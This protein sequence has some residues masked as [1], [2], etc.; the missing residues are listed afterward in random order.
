LVAE[1][2]NNRID[3]NDR[4]ERLGQK[5]KIPMEAMLESQWKPFAQQIDQLEAS[6]SKQSPEELALM[7]DQ[8]ISKNNEIIAAL[9]AIL[10]DMIELQDL[11]EIIDRVRG[12][13]DRESKLIDRSKQQQKKSNLDQLK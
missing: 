11:N 10:A 9:N 7:L 3:S 6:L 1:L 8:S 2:I 12:L 4:R 13:I 5:I